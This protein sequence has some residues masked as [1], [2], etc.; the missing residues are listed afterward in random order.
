MSQ[1]S[2]RYAEAFYEA[3]AAKGLQDACLTD[4]IGLAEV[5]SA[6]GDVLGFFVNPSTTL[7]EKQNM[8]CEVFRGQ[9][10]DLT[11]NLLRLLLEKGRITEVPAVCDDYQVIYDSRKNVLRMTI[12]TAF[13]AEP[14]L[15]DK[16]VEKFRTQYGADEVKVETTIDPDIIGGAIIVIGDTMYD[17]SVR[18]KL[19]ALQAEINAD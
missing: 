7:R 12:T 17:E 11:L 9:T 6:G 1:I 4:L 13:E 2:E 8:M 10:E 15:I 5:F 3:A 19:Q 14:D 18:G 16:I